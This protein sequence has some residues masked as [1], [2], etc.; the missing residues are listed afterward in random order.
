MQRITKPSRKRPCTLCF[1]RAAIVV[2]PVNAYT[3]KPIGEVCRPCLE[4]L[5]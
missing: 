5:Y 1:R 3:G 2:L 4:Q